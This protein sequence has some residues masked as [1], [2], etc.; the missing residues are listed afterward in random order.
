MR[1]C[2]DEDPAEIRDGAGSARSTTFELQAFIGYAR[3]VIRGFGDQTTTD[4]FNGEDS[5]AARRIPK[6]LW[7]VARRKLD[8]INAAQ[9]LQ[10]LK[11]PPNNRLEKLKGELEGF[12]SI[13]VN[14]QYRVIF[15]WDSGHADDVQLT[16]YH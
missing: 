13:R 3:C 8:M 12:Y 5:K 14:D 16:D 15:R 11:V 7:P 4:I 9:D 2:R 6:A 1:G 10:D